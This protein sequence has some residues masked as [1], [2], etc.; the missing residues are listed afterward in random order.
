[1]A[2]GYTEEERKA[3]IASGE[4]A[5]Y[6]NDPSLSQSGNANKVKAFF[7]PIGSVADKNNQAERE[8]LRSAGEQQIQDIQQIPND[9]NQV[10]Y[11]ENRVRNEGLQGSLDQNN[12]RQWQ[13]T[14]NMDALDQQRATQ[15]NNLGGFYNNLAQ[16]SYNS[17]GTA[18]AADQQTLGQYSGALQNA[19]NWDM[20]NYGN[21]A[22]TYGGMSQLQARGY[23][24]DVQS[25]AS[26]AH[27]NAADIS[28]QYGAYD[29]LGGFASGSKD[30]QVDSA[31]D[32]MHRASL[33]DLQGIAGGSKDVG[34]GELDPEAYA[35]QKEAL[36]KYKE[37]LDPSV[38]ATERLMFA[39]AQQQQDQDERSNR[40]AV[41]ANQRQRGLGGGA[42]EIA[43]AAIGGQQISRNRQNSDL[44]A[45]ASA[46]ARSEAALAGYGGLSTAMNSAANDIATGNKNR[47][48][49]AQGMYVDATGKLRSATFAEDA[50]NKSAQLQA[51]GMQGDLATNMR[52]ESFNE[53]FST[54]SA[55]DQTAQ[56]NKS[57]SQLT[58]RFQD[59]YAADQQQQAAGRA[60][61]LNNAGNTVSRN[62]ATDQGNLAQAGFGVNAATDSRNQ[63]SIKTTQGLTNDWMGQQNAANESAKATA[64]G[65]VDLYG[66]QQQ[67]AADIVGSQNSNRN[68]YTQ[69]G[70]N[71]QQGVNDQRN[72]NKANETAL[73]NEQESF[74]A[75]KPSTWF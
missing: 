43:D 35:A 20:K 62:Y 69:N 1:M 71:I 17:S 6:G 64:A 37:R 55:A 54:K 8:R 26:G 5:G 16:Q 53:D 47:Q 61:S 30:A 75:L 44:A 60:E 34:V 63:N 49:T 66:R 25:Q 13:Q 32:A 46:Q 15:A 31:T 68:A 18:N 50:R 65:K 56:F 48:A 14:G 41:L 7:D 29:S 58:Q 2:Q 11:N 38:S 74:N 27:A 28:N 42:A 39:Q 52:N 70:I 23:G 73:K 24:A 40:S 51:T 9:Y 59:Q 45:L 72:V 22:D 33:G 21:L 3:A 4:L 10:G 19:T 36:G 57:Q 67:A 12:V